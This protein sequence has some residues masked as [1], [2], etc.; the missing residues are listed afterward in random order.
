MIP[1]LILKINET[2]L[3]IPGEA[4]IIVVGIIYLLIGF[5]GFGRRYFSKWVNG[6]PAVLD[7][8]ELTLFAMGAVGAAMLWPLLVVG[9]VLGK[10]L[11]T[12]LLPLLA[13]KDARNR[14][15]LDR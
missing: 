2:P 8:L 15:R 6:T 1:D 4:A 11:G 14:L 9:F 13:N 7:A 10:L 12:V 5:L 3:T